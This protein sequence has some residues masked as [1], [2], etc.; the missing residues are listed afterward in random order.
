MLSLSLKIYC[1]FQV[2]SLVSKDGHSPKRSRACSWSFRAWNGRSSLHCSTFR[3]GLQVAGAVD[4]DPVDCGTCSNICAN[5][6]SSSTRSFCETWSQ[7]FNLSA[8]TAS[9]AFCTALLVEPIKT[10]SNCENT[11]EIKDLCTYLLRTFRHCLLCPPLCH[12]PCATAHLLLP[13]LTKIIALN[14][15]LNLPLILLLQFYSF[16]SSLGPSSYPKHG[17]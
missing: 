12:N 6:D 10:C 1:G 9:K 3:L 13:F 17:S 2:G 7:C 5:F 8:N 15:S 4:L 11:S 16:L 14:L